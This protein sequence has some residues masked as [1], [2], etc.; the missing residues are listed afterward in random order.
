[1]ILENE[2]NTCFFWFESPTGSGH[3]RSTVEQALA[4]A[5]Q[6]H[7]VVIVTG[8]IDKLKPFAHSMGISEESDFWNK[9][10]ETKEIESNL[11]EGMGKITLVALEPRQEKSIYP[12]T[13][14]MLPEQNPEP[15]VEQPKTVIV[16]SGGQWIEADSPAFYQAALEAYK[17][18]QQTQKEHPLLSE[19]WKLLVPKE[20]VAK[21]EAMVKGLGN[22][23]KPGIKVQ[24]NLPSDVFDET[25][26]LRTACLIT[27]GGY[28]I[29]PAAA[30][31]VPTTVIPRQG[32]IV[33]HEQALR[34]EAFRDAGF[35]TLV[36]DVNEQTVTSKG[37]EV[38]N[39]MMS[40]VKH[41]PPQKL[42][43]NAANDVI[44]FVND[45]LVKISG[46]QYQ[47]RNN[48]WVGV[49]GN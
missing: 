37:C 30:E 35:V 22:L 8:N 42:L 7:K 11:G 46:Y 20:G 14:G 48:G 39:A 33:D 16:T 17:Y 5:R 3:C 12:C 38:T 44:K 19:P 29:A 23:G 13:D 43:C 24:Q 6:G 2:N 40:A 9:N 32:N 31:D 45:D 26:S 21:I 36:E 18:M 4:Y 28:T 1:M 47:P 10:G 27:R 41:R 15:K 49:R 25:I 34:A